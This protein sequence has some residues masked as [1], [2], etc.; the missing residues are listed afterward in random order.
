MESSPLCGWKW[1]N[2]Q[3]KH[4]YITNSKSI[5]YKISRKCHLFYQDFHVTLTDKCRKITKFQNRDPDTSGH[6]ES[7]FL[8][9]FSFWELISSAELCWKNC[10]EKAINLVENTQNW[11][12]SPFSLQQEFSFTIWLLQFYMH[13]DIL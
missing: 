13:Y 1:K 6:Q 3:L 2:I 11:W 9:K 4:Y 5:L 8:L 10:S 12:F 7:K